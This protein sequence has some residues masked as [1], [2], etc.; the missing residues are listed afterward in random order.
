VIH[1]DFRFLLLPISTAM[2]LSSCA[3]VVITDNIV[4]I[5]SEPRGILMYDEK[6][7][8]IGPTP[9]LK[10]SSGESAE[11]IKYRDEDDEFKSIRH[12]CDYR[13][14]PLI[15]N[16]VLGLAGPV[17]AAV[18]LAIDLWGTGDGYDCSRFPKFRALDYNREEREKCLTTIVAPPEHFD[19]FVS[20]T[21]AEDYIKSSIKIDGRCLKIQ[22]YMNSKAVLAY[23]NLNHQRIP[24]PKRIGWSKLRE[25]GVQSSSSHLV[26][27]EV[28]QTKSGIVLK[29]K[30]YDLVRGRELVSESKAIKVPAPDDKH[31]LIAEVRK[32]RWL[33]D[34]LFFLPNSIT[35]AGRSFDLNKQ[36]VDLD[37]QAGA[38]TKIDNLPTYLSNW[39]LTWVDH[40]ARY[41]VFD[42]TG[43]VYPNIEGGYHKERTPFH[44]VGPE[45]EGVSNSDGRFDIKRTT[46][47]AYLLANYNAGFTFH[48]PIGALGAGVGYGLSGFWSEDEEELAFQFKPVFNLRFEYVGFMSRDFF[49]FVRADLYIAGTDRRSAPISN[50]LYSVDD[51]TITAV[52]IGYFLPSMRSAARS[53]F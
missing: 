20:D 17:W 26:S 38:S 15:G 53:L 18:G 51:W 11:I 30:V 28:D 1:L 41:N 42:I 5:D 33:I 3:T 9:L 45:I 16:A 22:N 29:Q 14:L 43:Q 31:A 7:H 39:G 35:F 25:I 50:D 40:P 48:S 13:Y 44:Y 23:Y 47:F 32:K 12:V 46:S 10:R 6:G 34:S 27:L 19:E 49:F 52:G 21:L 24:D 8:M 36:M 4:P 37:Y 2:L